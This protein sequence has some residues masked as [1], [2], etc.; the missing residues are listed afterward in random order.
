MFVADAHC[1]TL[2]RLEKGAPLGSISRE[3]LTLGGVALQVF[4]LFNGQPPHLPMRWAWPSGR[5]MR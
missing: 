2:Y 4:A 1:D 5:W 3:A